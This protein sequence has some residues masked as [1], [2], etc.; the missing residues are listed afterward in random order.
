MLTLPGIL[1]WNYKCLDLDVPSHERLVFDGLFT[2]IE[3][4]LDMLMKKMQ[5]EEDV[6]SVEGRLKR[7]SRVDTILNER[8]FENLSVIE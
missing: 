8:K 7:S 2:K 5:A 6:S 4:L 3:D 1:L